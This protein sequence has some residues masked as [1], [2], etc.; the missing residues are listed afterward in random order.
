MSNIAFEARSVSKFFPGVKALQNV[1]MQMREGSIHALLGENGAGKSTLIKLVTGV[2]R[3]DEG[4]LFAGSEPVNFTRPHDAIAAGVGVVHQERNLIPRF[5]VAENM[6]LS[7]L[8]DRL[9]TPI[10]YAD[11]N[12]QARPWLDMLGIDIDPTTQVSRLSVAQRQMVEIAKALSLQTRVLLLDEPT[13]SL[14]PMESKA[15]FDVLHRLRDDGVSM[16]FVSHKLEEVK[17]ICDTVSVLRDGV[18]AGENIAMES[19]ERQDLIRLM[20]GREESAAKPRH[21]RAAGQSVALELKKVSTALGHK[22]I[23]LDVKRHEIVGLYG[24]VGA[25]RTELAKA[26]MGAATITGGE[27][28]RNGHTVRI[29]NPTDALHRHKIGYVSENRKDEGL[30]L[31]HSVLENAG[32][33]V[34]RKSANRLGWLTR[35]AVK[36]RTVPFLDKLAVKTPSLT[37][38][39]G[40]L[41]GGN[42][43]KIAMAKWLAAGVE[44]LIVDEPTVGIDVKSKAYLHELLHE[45]AN[46][47]TAVLLITSDLPEMISLADRILVMDEFVIKGDIRNTGDYKEISQSV[48]EHIHHTEDELH[49]VNAAVSG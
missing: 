8:A 7:Q 15:M 37:Q 45:L 27:V 31:E 35:A 29:D 21:S 38:K 14:T 40:N 9:I 44:V 12:A 10:D 34:W 18:N 43:Q 16:L 17:E 48:M 49:H 24:L 20:I 26:I 19:L 2:Y 41:S 11:L 22:N 13:A 30:I 25:G 33:T 36:K 4:Q 28:L 39:V 23:N 5:S 32:I 46:D 1:S 3:P 47:G 6:A 42:Q